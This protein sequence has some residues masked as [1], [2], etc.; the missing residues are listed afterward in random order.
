MV[1]KALAKDPANRFAS[2]EEFWQALDA[3]EADPCGAALGGTASYAA[4]AAAAGHPAARLRRPRS[5]P[6]HRGFFTPARLDRSWRCSCLPVGAALAYAA[7]SH[8][9]GV[10]PGADGDR[11]D[12]GRAPRRSSA[13]PGSRSRSSR[14][15]TTPSPRTVLEQDPTAGSQRRQ[16]LHGDDHG[17][18]RAGDGRGAGRRGAAREAG[19]EDAQ[20]AR[21]CGP[22]SGSA[23]RRTVKTGLAIGTV[24]AAG[25]RA[26]ARQADHPARLERSEAGPGAV[27]DRLPAGRRG[28]RDPRRG[29][30]PNFE[31]RDSDAPAGE[32][33]AQDP[34]AGSTVKQHTTVTVVVSN[35]AGTAVVPNV[36]GESQDQ[37]KG[38]LKA[39]GLSVRIVKRTTTDANEDGTGPRSI[40][41]RRHAPAARRVRDDLRRQV[42]GRRRPRRRP[43][44]PPRPTP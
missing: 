26:R 33:I 12:A 1:L 28:H 25:S 31:N 7:D 39:A 9:R 23:R 27:G 34:A 35:G 38:D 36:V 5:P 20:G 19:A 42:H 29:L 18:Q 43:R 16:G 2:A 4:V 24:P 37:A 44:P 8:G 30:I 17:L 22:R 32:V 41:E 21:A 15:P 10:G 40:A 13:T 6:E 14:C 11:Q 3:A